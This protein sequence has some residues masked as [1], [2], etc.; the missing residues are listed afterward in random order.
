MLHHHCSKHC[1]LKITASSNA[2]KRV[3][4]GLLWCNGI[5]L[6]VCPHWQP[7]ERETK[8]GKILLVCYLL[9]LHEWQ[10]GC[11]VRLQIKEPPF[12]LQL[13]CL[14]QKQLWLFYYANEIQR[15]DCDSEDFTCPW[16]CSGACFTKD[17]HLQ[18]AS[19]TVLM[20]ARVWVTSMVFFFD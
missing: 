17:Q 16:Y 6:H 20:Y 19:P 11:G 14:P 18:I 12:Q 10:T 15:E 8:K 7:G 3:L 9:I 13:P 2:I 4:P 1:S 5:L